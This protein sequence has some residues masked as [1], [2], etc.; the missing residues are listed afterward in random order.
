MK[1]LKKTLVF[2]TSILVLLSVT[3]CTN[4]TTV[5]HSVD[6]GKSMQKPMKSLPASAEVHTVD[7]GYNKQRMHDYESFVEREISLELTKSLRDKGYN[8]TFTSKRD[9]HNKRALADY[10]RL[11]TRMHDKFDSLYKPLAKDVKEAY[12]ITDKVKLEANWSAKFDN[13]LVVISKY[14]EE[15]KTGGAQ[16]RDFLIDAFVGSHHSDIAEASTLYVGIIEF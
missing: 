8:T 9:L 6:Y 11:R 15:V 10:D 3:A 5:R 1:N 14:S 2:A 4:T 13:N 16:A 7:V 12:S